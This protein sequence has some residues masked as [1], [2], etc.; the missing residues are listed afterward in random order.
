MLSGCG[1]TSGSTEGAALR[2]WGPLRPGALA[3][4][5]RRMG[6]LR[7]F[8]KLGFCAYGVCSLCGGL[9][10]QAS[11]CCAWRDACLHH[12]HSLGFA[13]RVFRRAFT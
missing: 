9:K 7:Q 1:G 13:R 4:A 12:A 8:C 3:G 10:L 11:W 5:S 2:Q 6:T